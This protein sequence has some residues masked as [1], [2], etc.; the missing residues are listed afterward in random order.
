MQTEHFSQ[1]I[2]FAD[3]CYLTFSTVISTLFGLVLPFSILIIFDRVLPNQAKDTRFLR[4][5]IIVI[6]IFLDYHL[7]NQGGKISSVVM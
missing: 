4:F 7:K 6:T 3:K 2:N 1:K 5:A